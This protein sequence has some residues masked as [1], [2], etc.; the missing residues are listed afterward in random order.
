LHQEIT[1]TKKKG[2]FT[3]EESLVQLIRGGKI[4]REAAML[5]AIHPD[6]LEILLRS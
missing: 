1:L 3:M 6:D 5:W 2:S 4:E